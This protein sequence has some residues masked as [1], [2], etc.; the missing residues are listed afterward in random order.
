[1][2]L[3]WKEHKV[4][5][6]SLGGTLLIALSS[7][8]FID[9]GDLVL[10]FSDHRNGFNN[11]F[12]RFANLLGEGYAFAFFFLILLFYR[13]RYAIAVLFS[14]F[15]AM[16]IS[17]ALKR[18]FGH[19][20]PSKYLTELIEH[21]VEIIAVPEVELVSSYTSSFPSG[22]TTAAFTLYTLLA[23][24]YP[25]ASWQISCIMLASLAALAR[26][27]LGQHFLE[28][29]TAGAFCGFMIGSGIFLLQE[30]LKYYH[31][32]NRGISPFRKKNTAL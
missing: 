9:K 13:F 12:F 24:I 27:Y 7:L 17:Q 10:Y 28:D 30:K 3:F 32:A 18:Y 21:P 11:Y 6:I 22:H 2:Q 19:P 29:I 8:L 26:V 5:L 15:S 16:F 20:R 31:W 23:F 14:G 4:Y 1:M 25:K